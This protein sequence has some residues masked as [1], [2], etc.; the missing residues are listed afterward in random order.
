MFLVNE[1]ISVK[2]R[3]NPWGYFEGFWFAFISPAEFYFTTK[4]KRGTDRFCFSKSRQKRKVGVK[5]HTSD[6]SLLPLSLQLFQ[7]NDGKYNAADEL[8]FF[9]G[10]K[11]LSY[12]CWTTPPVYRTYSLAFC[13]IN[14]FSNKALF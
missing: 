10:L 12:Y 3:G 1:L 7:P 8:C 11:S 9:S 2:Y 13:F 4:N 14:S 5:D 6:S